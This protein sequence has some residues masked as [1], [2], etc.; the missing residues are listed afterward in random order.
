[1]N[2]TNKFN[3]SRQYGAYRKC[4]RGCLFLYL[5]N[6]GLAGNIDTSYFQSFVYLGFLSVNMT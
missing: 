6:T 1:M 5:R 3:I 4:K 2:L